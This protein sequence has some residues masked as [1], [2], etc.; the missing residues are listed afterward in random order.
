MIALLRTVLSV[1]LLVGASLVA[2]QLGSHAPWAKIY[3]GFASFTA[4]AIL[5][6]DYLPSRKAGGSEGG[7][8]NDTLGGGALFLVALLL[9]GMAWANGYVPLGDRV[10][11]S[12]QPTLFWL[13]IAFNVGL[14]VCGL[15]IVVRDWGL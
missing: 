11:R 3:L 12:E 1:G 10:Y 13:V 6:T 7:V 15:G 14:A 2:P 4:V 8:N 5:L 9:L